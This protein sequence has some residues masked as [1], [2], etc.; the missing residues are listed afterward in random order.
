MCISV[1]AVVDY[2]TIHNELDTLLKVSYIKAVVNITRICYEFCIDI[3]NVK[4][5]SSYT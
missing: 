1:Q 5:K 4:T 2:L 3:I